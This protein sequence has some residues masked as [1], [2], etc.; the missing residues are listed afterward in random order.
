MEKK[1]IFIE[2]TDSTNRYLHDYQS[3]GEEMIIVYTDFQTAGRG[4]GTNHWESERGK[5]ITFSILT[6]PCWMPVT[7]QFLLSMAGGLAIKDVLDI[8]TE[9]ITIKWPN[10]I[11]W[12]DKKISGTLIE[13]SVSGKSIK[14]CIF[15]VGI[16]INQQQFLSDAPNPVSLSQ[17][18][19]HETDRMEVLRKIVERFE[20]YLKVLQEKDYDTVR[21]QYLQVMYRREGVFEY[22]DINGHFF[23]CIQTVEEDG[24][25]VLKRTD[26]QLSSYA[27]K[28]VQFVIHGIDPQMKS[29]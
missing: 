9:G 11:Y 12:H 3:D 18:I 24:H 27:F 6:H 28:E 8:Y 29:E 25:L 21:Q 4:Q 23:A 10:D 14:D 1:Y 5:N 26:E 7:K 15:G 22:K 2:E 17:I 13:T 19:G 20:H 16:N